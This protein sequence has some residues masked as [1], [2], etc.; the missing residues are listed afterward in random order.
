[1]N[2]SRGMYIR[3]TAYI[4][5][6]WK[7]IRIADITELSEIRLGGLSIDLKGWYQLWYYG[8]NNHEPRN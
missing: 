4:P 7:D 6:N 3:N 8:E 1:M 2:S 5:Q